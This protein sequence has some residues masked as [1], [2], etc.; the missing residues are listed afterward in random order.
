[1]RR[2]RN[3]SI[4]CRRFCKHCKFH[5]GRASRFAFECT[6][7]ARVTGYDGNVNELTYEWTNGLGTYLYV[8]N[9]HNM[10]SINGTNDE[11][12]IYNDSVE[13]SANMTGRSYEDTF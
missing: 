13:S 6:L 10:Y 1:M 7:E 12:E 3:D 4:S 2:Y 11:I 5:K 8:F 9:S